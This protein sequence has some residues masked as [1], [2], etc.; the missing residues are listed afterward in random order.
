MADEPLN[1]RQSDAPA[2]GT[3][4]PGP[5]PAARPAPAKTAAATG[6]PASAQSQPAAAKLKQQKP[7]KAAVAQPA[8]V[9]AEEVESDDFWRS[10]LIM[11]PS[12][13]VS[14]V[15]HM[16]LILVLA[17]IYMTT[18]GDQG[19]AQIVAAPP[20]EIALDDLEDLINEEKE[21]DVTDTTLGDP[22]FEA[23][24]TV[25]I[26]PANDLDA[27]AQMV[28][29]D[30]AGTE[31]APRNLTQTIGAYSGTGLSGRGSGAK[32]ALLARR[33]G[34]IHSE[35][36]V[37]A[38][39]EWLKRHQLPD[40]GWDFDL[41]KCPNCGGRC[42][43]S[44][45]SRSRNAA[46]ALALLPFLGAGQTHK[47][48]KY[49]DVVYH[50]LMFLGR[51]MK[52]DGA[53]N[54]SGN[55]YAH[56]LAA[57]ALCEAF[58]MT[59]DKSLHPAAQRSVDFIVYA[60]DPVGGGWRYQPKQAG[61]TSVVGWQIMALKSGHMAY[62]R[63]P[64]ATVKKAFDFLDH[65]QSNS[66]AN[67]GYTGPGQGEATTAIGL[68]CRMYLGW[69]KDNPALQRGVE[70]L[71]NRGPSKG[72]MYYNYYATQVL[73]HWEGD[74]WKKWNS[75]MRD[76]LINTQA[77]EGCETGSWFFGEGGHDHGREQGGRLYFTALATMILEVYY[78][79]MP[80]YRSQSVDEDFPL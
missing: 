41:T 7:V 55:M 22:N 45:T 8:A 13:L 5:K 47:E 36:A 48:G 73:C 19:A 27:A 50:G 3:G 11:V 23:T 71:S 28:D 6:S 43:N 62:L 24:D 76:Y 69:K 64:P 68:L 52:P 56:G 26:S 58:A 49:R 46:T 80:I 63:V 9:E 25:M 35:K 59:Q 40:G 37:A 4:A 21:L 1:Q 66:G 77:T 61:D 34:N 72:N 42:R 20:E 18:E 32:G 79:H 29:L 51:Q 16:I 12:W 74:L 2:K 44:G 67:Y 57:I 17:M 33:G 10:F 75:V 14:L 54:D 15:V 70:W 65:V 39:L 60:Q 31:F 38:A 78:R 53:L 30:P